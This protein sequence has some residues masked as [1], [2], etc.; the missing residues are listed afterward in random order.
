MRSMNFLGSNKKGHEKYLKMFE[1]IRDQL[2]VAFKVIFD[3]DKWCRRALCRDVEGEQLFD[4]QDPKAVQWCL[5]GALYKQEDFS[6]ETLTFIGNYA[7]R[8]GI[9]D[10]SRYNDQDGHKAV[11]I[12]LSEALEIL[13]VKLTF[14]DENGK[15]TKRP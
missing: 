12:L 14:Y 4:P 10:L 11:I 5:L 15:E 1:L 3:E 7:K 2:L 6:Q 8:K 13:G 9:T